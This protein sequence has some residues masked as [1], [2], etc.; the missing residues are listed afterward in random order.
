MIS[1]NNT[2]IWRDFS[3]WNEQILGLAQELLTQDFIHHFLSDPPEE[4]YPEEMNWIASLLARLKPGYSAADF[5]VDF[6]KRLTAHYRYLRAFHGC[7]PPDLSS[8]FEQGIVPVDPQTAV[9]SVKRILL[10][11]RYPE[12][13]EK[14]IDE[15]VVRRGLCERD[16]RIYFG[17]DDRFLIGHCGHYLLYGSEY[18]VGVVAE[19]STLGG[20]DYRRCFKGLG[21]PTMLVCDIPWRMISEEVHRSLCRALLAESFRNLLDPSYAP[22]I[23]DF[24]FAI[25]GVLPPE[26]IVS[27]Y[28]PDKIRDPLGGK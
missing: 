5:E 28:S 22:S 21:T 19:L 11:G 6:T 24:G 27:H 7:C 15:A 2:F 18:R 9:D 20:P 14:Q 16:K 23:I 1:V 26:H 25:G 4:V 13:T 17:L 3:S 12:L 8:Y 10:C